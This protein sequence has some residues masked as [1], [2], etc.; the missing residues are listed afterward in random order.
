M[1]TSVLC[2]ERDERR[3]KSEEVV[4]GPMLH[5]GT[6]AWFVRLVLYPTTTAAVLVAGSSQYGLLWPRQAR[7]EARIAR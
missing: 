5:V 3:E 7:P 2:D 6:R 1:K 4:A